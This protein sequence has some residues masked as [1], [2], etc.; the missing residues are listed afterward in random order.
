MSKGTNFKKLL[1]TLA[2]TTRLSLIHLSF[3]YWGGIFFPRSSQQI[4]PQIS[5]VR[6]GQQAGALAAKEAGKVIIG[7]PLWKASPVS[8]DKRLRE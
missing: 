7:L 4:S 3:K 2:V 6:D 5:L 8:K 1:H